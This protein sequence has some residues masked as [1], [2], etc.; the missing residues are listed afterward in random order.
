MAK[1]NLKWLL[2]NFHDLLLKQRKGEKDLRIRNWALESFFVF[3][4]SL[5]TCRYFLWMLNF[6]IKVILINFVPDMFVNVNQP[7]EA[8]FKVWETWASCLCHCKWHQHGY[9]IE[10]CDFDSS[11][12]SSLCLGYKCGCNP[13]ALKQWCGAQSHG[14]EHRQSGGNGVKLVNDSSRRKKMNVADLHFNKFS[15]GPSLFLMIDWKL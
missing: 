13:V 5:W 9:F 12:S 1:F 14:R 8:V 7:D 10:F 11:L 3:W 2:C 4:L 15:L 6:W